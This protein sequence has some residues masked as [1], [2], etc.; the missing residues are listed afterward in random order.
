MTWADL[1]I[2]LK[3]RT[4]GN[5]KTTCPKCI[6]DRRNKRDVSLSVNITEG[7]FNCH[8][9]GWKGSINEKIKKEK[10]YKLPVKNN[11]GLSDNSL[12]WFEGRGISKTTIMRFGLTEGEEWMP[13]TEKKMNCIHFNYFRNDQLINVKFRDGKKNFKMVS[14][15][16]LIFY[17]LDLIKDSKWCVI[18]EGEIDAMSFYEA[19]IHPVLSVPNGASKGNQK[20]EYLDNCWADFENMDKI[21]LATDNDG[22]GISLREELARRLGKHR[23]FIV[24]FPDGIK[25]ANE[26]IQQKGCKS[27]LEV[28]GQAAQYPLEGI[29]QVADFDDAI[30]EI[31]ING[32][33]KGKKIGFNQFDDL[34]TFRGGE[35]TA[36][37]GIP[38][39]GK[40][41]FIDQI[42]IKLAEVNGWTWGVF[43]AENQPLEI[44]FSKL[45]EKYTGKRFHGINEEYSMNTSDLQKAKQFL[46]DHFF[47]VRIEEENLTLDA[48]LA[49]IKELVLRKGIKGFLLDPWNYV[50]H[51]RP[52]GQTETDY[53]SESLTKVC[54]VAKVYD[55]HIFIVAHPVKIKKTKDGKKY[56]V[57]TL[58][59]IAGSAHWFNKV[60][61]GI[62]VYRDYVTGVVDVHVQKVRFKFIGHVGM[63][64]FEWDKYTGKYQEIM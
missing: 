12:K 7:I 39:S 24:N 60:D 44:H 43:S 26:M 63:A 29:S 21:Y 40:S 59:D 22:P 9:C 33:P 32:F 14:G 64:S 15:A 48:L 49:K 19:G 8:H 20:L 46:N 37:T 2:D 10:E 6:H 35:V 27:L 38:G 25:D 51:K 28:F 50:D 54:R 31:Y 52:M 11:S 23:C 41:E 4:S 17:G 55:V 18:C 5:H 58:Y 47:F 30:N 62:S 13:Q 53:I 42:M 61:N 45:S 3:G 56:E 1:D 34:L 36:V 16:E 57:A